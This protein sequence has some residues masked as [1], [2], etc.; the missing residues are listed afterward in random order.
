MAL[1]SPKEFQP[2]RKVQ[3]DAEDKLRRILEATAKAIEKRIAT[4]KP[5]IGGVVRAAQLRLVLRQ[6]R[7]LQQKMWVGAI[8]PMIA[9]Q[10]QASLEA[11]ESA[12]EALTRVAYGAMN[13]PA[14]EQLIR[15]LKAA[16]AAGL[17]ADAVRRRRALS[18][19][20]YKIA[21]L[22]EDKVEDA[23]RAGIIANLSARELA[24]DVYQYISPT[25][26]GGAAYAAQ[27]LARTE[28][29]NAFHERQIQGAS[30]PGVKAV[31]WN[32]S[33][34]HPRPDECNLYAAHEPFPPDAVPDKPHPNCFCYL[35]YVTMSPEEFVEALDRGAFDDE[36]DRRT[37]E[38]LARLGQRVGTT[39]PNPE[40]GSKDRKVPSN[41]D[42][43]RS[44]LSGEKSSEKLTGGVSAETSKVEFNDGS[45]GVKK[46]IDNN[47]A[48]RQQDAEELVPMLARMMGLTA[49]QVHRVDEKT[50][51]QSF[52]SGKIAAGALP[53]LINP[54]TPQAKR[55]TAG[56]RVKKYVE[57]DRGWLMGVLDQVTGN[58]D[59]HDGNWLVDNDLEDISGVIDHGLAYAVRDWRTKRHDPHN[60]SE[61]YIFRTRSEFTKKFAKADGSQSNIDFHPADLDAIAEMLVALRPEYEKRGRLDWWNF[62][63]R[64]IDALRPY[65][66][67][68]KRRIQ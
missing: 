54:G 18:D 64:Q 57:S 16:A 1:P 49:P 59:R 24:Q 26:K 44:V 6:V 12:V 30:R 13:E 19:R 65:A 23:I 31:Q 47:T 40:P 22:H 39:D 36:L 28:I 7:Q 61:P 67:G 51:V 68:K 58:Q 52:L 45:T 11:G 42:I 4:L 48:K 35:T 38:N 15:G 32:L 3:G 33:N 63:M 43:K 60:M 9:G 29:N 62:S 56:T 50:T 66:K 5:G 14:A 37:K 17:K 2:Y 55:L 34:S 46:F 20:V 27:R 8:T 21:A 53:W 10:I 41:A 25:T